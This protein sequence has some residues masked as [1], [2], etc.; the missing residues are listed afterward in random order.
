MKI[1]FV[2]RLALGLAIQSSAD[3]KDSA[4]IDMQVVFFV[5]C[6]IGMCWLNDAMQSI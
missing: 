2:L 1:S 6:H 5:F 4:R 3:G